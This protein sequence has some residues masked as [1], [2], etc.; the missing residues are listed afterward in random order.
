MRTFK[1]E[2]KLDDLWGWG[3]GGA[4][5][6]WLRVL[7]SFL[8]LFGQSYFLFVLIHTRKEKENKKQNKKRKRKRNQ[9]HQYS[10]R[11]SDFY[12]PHTCR[13]NI[14]KTSILFQGPRI[15]NSLPNDIKNAPSFSIFKRVIKPF[16]RVRQNAT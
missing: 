15:W 13:T 6:L 5:T 9:I 14:K 2:E 11:Y 10:A 4:I 7:N 12:R 16:L 1:G 3:E 8:R